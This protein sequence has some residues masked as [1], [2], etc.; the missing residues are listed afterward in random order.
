MTV[1]TTIIDEIMKN[2][3][4]DAEK[5]LIQNGSG[6]FTIS[7][8]WKLKNDPER[9]NKYS[10][11]IAIFVPQELIEDFPNYPE[12]M[13]KSA[14]SKLS[15]YISSQLNGFDPEHSSLRGF[16]EPVEQ[17]NIPIEHLFG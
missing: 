2:M 16:P 10:K 12:H 7:V 14:L 13:Q 3:P 1:N 11:T 8:H 15:T 9:P 6:S 4:R 5:Y 17:W